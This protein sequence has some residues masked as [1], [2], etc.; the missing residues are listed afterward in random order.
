MS[1]V[2]SGDLLRSWK[3]LFFVPIG[4]LVYNDM[5]V[6]VIKKVVNGQVQKATKT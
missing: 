3:T 5:T 6:V 4:Q 1:A 2:F